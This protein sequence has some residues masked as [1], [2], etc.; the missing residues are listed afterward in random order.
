MP[1]EFNTDPV[2][3]NGQLGVGKNLPGFRQQRFQ[4]LIA[5]GI[6]TKD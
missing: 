3:F 6:M 1:F 2:P 4:V 5:D